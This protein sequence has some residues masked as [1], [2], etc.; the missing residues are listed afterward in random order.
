MSFVNRPISP[1]T[2]DVY[3]ITASTVTIVASSLATTT[4][5]TC[6]GLAVFLGHAPAWLPMISDCA[7]LPP[8]MFLFRIGMISAALLLNINSLL[9]FFYLNSQ[10][11]GKRKTS[12]SVG[13]VIVSIGCLGLAM[14]GAINEKENNSVH[15]ISAVTFFVCYIIYMITI[16]YRL[17]PFKGGMKISN[18]SITMKCILTVISVVSFILFVYFNTNR[19]EYQLYIAICEWI[20]VGCIIAYNLTF[21]FEYKTDLNLAAL[22]LPTSQ[23]NYFILQEK[24]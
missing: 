23:T 17:Y 10:E 1:G 19:A 18:T 20:G 7:L 3:E 15:G 6:Y 9:M 24:I 12:D 22:L 4:I 13:M 8:E 11:F 5:L 14:V 16:T 21:T 2:E